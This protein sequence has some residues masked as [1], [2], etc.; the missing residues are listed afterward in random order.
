MGMLHLLVLSLHLGSPAA[1][2]YAK[3]PSIRA[4]EWLAVADGYLKLGA[5]K[6]PEWLG[7]DEGLRRPNQTANKPTPYEKLSELKAY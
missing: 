6:D 5:L 4:P 1:S 3:L 2:G 7:I